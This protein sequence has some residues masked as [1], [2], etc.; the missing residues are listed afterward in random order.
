[1]PG[2]LEQTFRTLLR[3]TLEARG[4][5]VF[6]DESLIRSGDVVEKELTLALHACDVG[7]VL[8]SECAIRSRWV[9]YE[10]AVLYSRVLLSSTEDVKLI[11]IPF[12]RVTKSKVEE[13]FEPLQASGLLRLE[14]TSAD[15]KSQDKVIADL[16]KD[17]PGPGRTVLSR[18]EDRL[19]QI[20]EG[21][22]FKPK[23]LK[24]M[25]QQI[26]EHSDGVPIA[27]DQAVVIAQ[28][29]LALRQPLGSAR[30]QVLTNV[31]GRLGSLLTE[32]QDRLFH[33]V[34]PFCWVEDSEAFRLRE[35]AGGALPPSES[36]SRRAVAWQ[37]SW[38]L[39]EFMYL[40][41]SFS[42]LSG[43]RYVTTDDRS[44]DLDGL[45]RHVR[46]CLARDLLGIEDG[47]P[48]TIQE[49]VATLKSQGI[50][51]FVLVPLATLDAPMIDR[52]LEDWSEVV[53]FFYL[54]ID[55]PERPEGL[56]ELLEGPEVT[57]LSLDSKHER[58]A[59]RC[60]RGYRPYGQGHFKE[61]YEL[62]NFLLG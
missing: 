9:Q 46:R 53:F 30:L 49:E 11:F 54:T 18:S 17:L 51:V 44:G 23:L 60:Y 56:D 26:P 61:R 7:I 40:L 59:A 2:T 10:L 48:E 33:F 47:R 19:L 4:Y 52:L 39:S 5:S 62:L 13:F 25:L 29:L 31:M 55:D 36:E 20:L 43:V 28:K 24:K 16:L 37:R 3:D 22:S 34:F 14:L 58:S 35:V 42:D 8:L 50:P 38:P 1:M 21:D 45:R 15:Q 27:G 6:L 41:L 32:I 12:P 57:Q